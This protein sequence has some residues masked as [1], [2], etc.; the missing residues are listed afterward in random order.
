MFKHFI[1]F[2]NGHK[3]EDQG[4]QDT[5]AHLHLSTTTKCYSFSSRFYYKNDYFLMLEKFLMSLGGSF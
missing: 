4:I 1:D 3:R 2:F 5:L